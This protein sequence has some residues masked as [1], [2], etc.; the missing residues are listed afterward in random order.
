MGMSST[1][2]VVIRLDPGES[3]CGWLECPSDYSGAASD[4]TTQTGCV[5]PDASRLACQTSRLL[6]FVAGHDHLRVGD[7]NRVHVVVNLVAQGRREAIAGPFKHVEA[8]L[9]AVERHS[10]QC[11]L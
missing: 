6:F 5:Q 10:G 8:H 9:R 3:V 11:G 4:A 1:L 7:L 2:M